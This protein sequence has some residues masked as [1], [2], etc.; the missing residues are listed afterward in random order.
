MNQRGNSTGKTG[1]TFPFLQPTSSWLEHCAYLAAIYLS[2][3]MGH[4]Y[5]VTVAP[6]MTKVFFFLFLKGLYITEKLKSYV[7]RKTILCKSLWLTKT[8][9]TRTKTVAS[10]NPLFHTKSKI[11]RLLLPLLGTRWVREEMNYSSFPEPTKAKEI[12]KADLLI[13][14]GVV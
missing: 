6:P 14:T 8:S 5:A 4:P 10:W 3:Q 13:E 1:P 9:S 2:Q 7:L 11:I 12:L